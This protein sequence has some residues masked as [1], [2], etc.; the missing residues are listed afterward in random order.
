MQKASPS[1]SHTA[2]PGK[3]T[4]A[5][6][7]DANTNSN[8]THAPNT[9]P[10]GKPKPTGKDFWLIMSLILASNLMAS[11]SQSL[12][13]IA[14]DTVATDFHI[15]LSVANWMVLGF[16]IVAGTMITT[17]G[18]LLKRFGLRKI[19]TVGYI[20]SIV[21]SMLGFF[22]WD[23][24]SMLVARLIQALTVGIFFPVITS[25]ILAIAPNGRSGT[26]LAVNS[27]VIGVGLAFAPL[28]TGWLLT[29]VGLHSLFL[30]PAIMSV[31]LLVLGLMFF[32]DI[33]DR[34]HKKID[35]ISVVLSF[36]GMTLLIYGLNEITRDT[37]PSL[38]MVLAGLVVI[39]L[40]AWRQF[41]IP[42][43]LLNL[44]PMKHPRFVLGETLMML[45][46]MG[47]IYMS[48]LVPLYLEGAAGMSAFMTGML[49]IAPIL[50]YAI[51]CFIGGRIEDA[52][53]IWPLV[54]IGFLI[55]LVGYIGMEITSSM[56]L[57]MAMVV[58]VGVSFAGVGLVF[59]TLKASDLSVLPQDITAYGSSIHSTLVQIAGSLGS[60]IFV[61]IMSADVDRLIAHGASKAD[62]YS[63]GFSH[64]LIIALVI[65]AVAF[66]GSIVYSRA[67][68]RFDRKRR[69][70]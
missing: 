1:H 62:A 24:A 19:M 6:R 69:K 12:M 61:G 18:T 21:G 60:A 44:E 10:N 70:S 27:G 58:C 57:T 63:A 4:P 29:Y 30:V 56:L 26:M 40:F 64:T 16:T 8:A 59:P 35:A 14:L 37:L 23:F 55:L 32:H 43:P 47:S 66:V 9:L 39:A 38:G 11:F 22:A 31:I 2:H 51:A 17:A 65:L 34:Q 52:H 7:D 41:K 45:G 5:K 54:P 13:N 28:L 50:C 42:D 48:L 3:E 49:L 20:A 36:I 68:V 46:Y 25:V 33:M 15:S 53:G 67:V